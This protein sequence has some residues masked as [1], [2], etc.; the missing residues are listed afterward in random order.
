MRAEA[1]TPRAG[2]PWRLPTRAPTDPYVLALE[3]TVPQCPLVLFAPR[4]T[5]APPKPG[6]GDPVSPAGTSLRKRQDLP[7]SWRTLIVRLHMFHTDAGRTADTRPLRCRDMALGHRTAKAPAKGLSTLNSMAFGLAVYASQCRLPRPT[8]NSL[9]VAGQA[10][11]GRLSTRKVPMKG[12]R[13]ASYISFSLPKLSWRNR[14]D[15]ST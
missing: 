5:S 2:W 3:H 15:R 4:R 14:C 12:F 9:P 7:S 11:P 10:L 6:V 13:F 1:D 8:Q